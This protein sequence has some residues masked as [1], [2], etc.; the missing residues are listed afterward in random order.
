MQ[1]ASRGVEIAAPPFLYAAA[2]AAGAGEAGEH[3]GAAAA[4]HHWLSA[5][6]QQPYCPFA[7]MDAYA[8]R[9]ER[10]ADSAA[11]PGAAA[12]RPG[13]GASAAPEAAPAAPFYALGLGL[14][15]DAAAAVPQQGAPRFVP[16]ASGAWTQALPP[17]PA[18]P[19]S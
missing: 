2:L 1:G 8:Q 14:G 9:R 19:P 4:A 17:A 10:S 16:A 3:A 15:A 5:A 7:A 11:A 18:A 6:A 12:A 13:A